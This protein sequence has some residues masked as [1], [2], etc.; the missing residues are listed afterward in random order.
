M[1]RTWHP[2]R[3]SRHRV[4]AVVG[5]ALLASTTAPPAFAQKLTVERLAT[6][7]YLSGTP[8]MTPSWSP[9]GKRLAF[10]WND[11]ALPFRDIWLV[12]ASGANLRRL[13]DMA[14]VA[15]DTE[16][17]GLT[18]D[19]ARVWE[20][21]ARARTGIARIPPCCLAFPASRYGPV[22]TPDGRSL[23]FPYR[24][25][26]WSVDADGAA[27]PTRL[28]ESSGDKYAIGFSPDGTYISYLQDGDLWLWNR[29]TRERVQADKARRPAAR[30]HSGGRF[31]AAAGRV[32][33]LR[34]V[35]YRRVHRDAL[36]RLPGGPHADVPQL[37]HR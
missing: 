17:P 3:S 30:H 32:Q 20:V 13:T 19:A 11:Q 6:T 28:T 22:W 1:F 5:A 18:D 35:T 34:V 8:P 29:K 27:T 16:D 7:P 9:D 24:G 4:L 33:Q 12:D 14:K 26:I 31:H 36:R 37:P 23:V 21:V 10:L 25:A 2:F 15:P